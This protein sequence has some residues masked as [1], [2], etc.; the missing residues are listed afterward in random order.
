M[1]II[2]FSGG[3]GNQM[4][5]YAF[6]VGMREATKDECLMDVSKYKTYKLHNGF[7]LNR[8]FNIS[9]RT[10]TKD[11]IQKVS[12]YTTNYKLSRIYRKLLPNKHTEIV[13]LM[14]SCPYIPN[15]FTQ[16]KGDLYYEGIWQNYRYF[17]SCRDAILKEFN[18][19]QPL[20]S[21]N[22]DVKLWILSKPTVSIHI[23][24][25]DYLKH[26]I[27]RGLC[28]LEY[29]SRAIRYIDNK[30]GTSVQYAIFSNDIEWSKENVLPLLNGS[31]AKIIDW[32]TKLESYNDMRLM[33]Y[34]KINIL[35]NSS[36]SWWGAYL[37]EQPNKETIAPAKWV[38]PPVQF[39][40]QL[41]EWILL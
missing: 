32:N 7:E 9:A 27:Y 3:L 31:S 25:G 21:K 39:N 37:N 40:G 33:S 41:P 28:G 30:Y 18:Y 6:L 11:E 17:E 19:I 8:I 1:K 22:I 24:R 13:E 23:R 16:A 36:F 14:P 10:A 29:Y 38:N 4:F 2:N 35:A 20:S 5:Q 12:R 15:I 26:K 34:C